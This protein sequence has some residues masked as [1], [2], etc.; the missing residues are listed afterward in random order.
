MLT[1]NNMSM[2]R[3]HFSYLTVITIVGSARGSASSPNKSPVLSTKFARTINTHHVHHRHQQQTISNHRSNTIH[4]PSS[5]TRIHAPINPRHHETCA[6]IVP[7]AVEDA[8]E[9]A[10]SKHQRTHHRTINNRRR[11]HPSASVAARRAP[12]PPPDLHYN[13]Q[14]PLDHAPTTTKAGVTIVRSSLK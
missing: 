13:A 2:L 5:N 10:S 7:T 3:W 12:S 14:C 11:D 6:S 1:I 4:H 8:I 9:S